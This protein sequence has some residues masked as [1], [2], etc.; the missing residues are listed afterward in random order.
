MVRSRL[1]DQEKKTGQL[2]DTNLHKAVAVFRA[3]GLVAIQGAID[4]DAVKA[5]RQ[6]VDDV[7]NPLL[8]SRRRIRAALTYAMTNRIHLRSLLRGLKATELPL[9]LREQVGQSLLD[10]LTLPKLNIMEEPY[11]NSGWVLRER[12]DGTVLC[13][14]EESDDTWIITFDALSGRIDVAIKNEAPFNNSQF[15]RNGIVLPVLWRL[16]GSSMRLKSIHAVVA[17]TR[18]TSSI[19]EQHWHRDTPL[20]FKPDSHFHEP[21]IHSRANGIHIPVNDEHVMGLA[22]GV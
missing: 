5:F 21:G 10:L 7:L 1:S 19:T 13:S 18:N 4:Q 14:G 3:C 9:E 16:L 17:L 11:L 15:L 20:L 8:P 2:L 6:G 22:V 12:N